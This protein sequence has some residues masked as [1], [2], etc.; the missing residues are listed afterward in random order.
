MTASTDPITEALEA[1]VQAA[2]DNPRP[3]DLPLPVDVLTPLAMLPEWTLDLAA[4]L[5][6]TAG[7]DPAQAL[8]ALT[9]GSLTAGRTD[10]V[11]DEPVAVRWL[12]PEARA[13]VG[14]QARAARGERQLLYGLHDLLSAIE[15]DPPPIDLRAWYEVAH[16]LVDDPGGLALFELVDERS[17]DLLPPDAG[18]EASAVR[19]SLHY[20]GQAPSVGLL[21]AAEVLAAVLGGV[22]EDAA[23]RARWRIERRLLQAHDLRRLQGYCH[24]PE[25]EDRLAALVDGRGPVALH[26]RGAG[27]VGKTMTLRYLSSPAFVE[28]AGVRTPAIARVDFD[29]LDPAFPEQRP[30]LLLEALA[31]DLVDQVDSRPRRGASAVF[32]GRRGA[33]RG[34]GL[35]RRRL[36]PGSRQPVRPGRHRVIRRSSREPRSRSGPWC[37]SSTPARSSPAYRAME[38]SLRPSRRRSGSWRRCSP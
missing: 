12:T 37:W 2:I 1:A 9:G 10:F 24:R 18:G 19:S 3:A 36:A 34:G 38:W 5:V 21:A 35:P 23:R 17:L 16:S 32:S 25:I 28:R 20:G 6:A 29:H 8:P 13:E 15:S 27:G 4:R 33:L 22:V 11:S 26:L 7:A 31:I 14:R 30:L